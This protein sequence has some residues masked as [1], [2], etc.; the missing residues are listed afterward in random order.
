MKP[1]LLFAG[2]FL[3]VA[4]LFHFGYPNFADLDSFF[5]LGKAKLMLEQGISETSFPWTQFS[6]IKDNSSSLW[7]GFS[8]LLTPLAWLTNSTLALKIAGVLMTAFTLFAAFFIAKR[9]QWKWPVIWPFL[10]F[11]SAPNVM[12]QLLMIRPQTITIG[13]GLLLISFLV[14]GKRWQILLTAFLISWIHLNFAWMILAVWGTMA[15]FQLI[16]QKKFVPVN[17]A[18]VLTGGLLGWLARPNFLGAAKLFYIQVVQQIVEKQSGLPLLFGIENFPLS[19]NVLA[20][21]FS[22]FLIIWLIGILAVCW[23]IANRKT[24]ILPENKIMALAGSFLSVVFFLL[25]IAVARRA[26]DFW[27]AFGL[28]PIGVAFTEILRSANYH[29]TKAIRSFTFYILLLTF[30]FLTPYS[31]YKTHNSLTNHVYRPDLLKE[32]ALWLKNHS[33]PGE[34]VFNVHWSHFSPLFFWNRQNYYIGGLD[35]IFQYRHNPELYWKFHYLSANLTAE[36][37]CKYDACT[38]D[39]LEDTYAALKND[40]R[41]KYLLLDKIQNPKLNQY[42][43]VSPKFEKGFESINEVIYLIK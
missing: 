6:V 1:Y 36:F 5:Y 42:L 19:A 26:Y 22:V 2:L 23:L 14:R 9:H 29:T 7:F 34:I 38:K 24:I 15:I 32:A 21:N 39:Q 12:A 4:C 33:Q 3:L 13:L 37:T 41:A 30:C 17:L 18:A 20:K 25:S 35:P 43:K 8:I 10:M 28:L 27:I 31:M 40:F 16:T 11:F